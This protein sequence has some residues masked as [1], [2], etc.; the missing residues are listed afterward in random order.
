MVGVFAGLGHS[1]SRARIAGGAASKE[2]EENLRNQHLPA[3]GT[4]AKA[5]RTRHA[6]AL[7]IGSE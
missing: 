4:T 6:F 3:P 1:F 5:A 2:G 7:Y